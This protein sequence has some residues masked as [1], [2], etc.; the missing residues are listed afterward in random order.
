MTTKENIDAVIQMIRDCYCNK[1][2]TKQNKNKIPFE[3]NAQWADR[4]TT[5]SKQFSQNACPIKLIEICVFPVKSCA[6]FR[7]DTSW[8]MTR[9]GL[10]YDREWMIVRSTGVAMTQKSN[11]K[12]CLIQPIIDEARN[13]LQLNFPHADSISIP[14]QVDMGDNKTVSS[15]CQSKVCGDRIDGI[16]C[17]DNVA[18]WLSDVLLT[19]GLRL[20]RQNEND[21]RSKKTKIVTEQQA[22]SLTNQAQFLLINT[23]SV[24]WLTKKVHDWSEFDDCS[25]KILQN[26]IDR[27][28]GNLIIESIVPLEELD[29]QAICLGDNI[30]LQVNGPCTR[31]QM[32]CIDQSTGEKTTEPLQTI[33]R[34]F[35]GK[36]RF[37]I[38]LSQSATHHSDQERVISCDCK[39]SIEH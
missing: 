20:I 35:Q 31:C 3:R 24:D 38:Y 10:K 5:E 16:D 18:E 33:C 19:P 15:F 22:I 12:L 32:I 23:V 30:R 34:E 39:I 36:M 25:E 29:W 7:I 4:V 37:G 6:A 8:P 2:C 11:T 9:R 13:V 28:R 14:L 26:M 1:K 27:F 21:K 17:G